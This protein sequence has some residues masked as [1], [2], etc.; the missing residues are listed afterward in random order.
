MP[1]LFYCSDNYTQK[2]G[3]NRLL[4]VKLSND[5]SECVIPVDGSI[6]QFHEVYQVNRCHVG[7]A[8][9]KNRIRINW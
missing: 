1:T 2:A 7:P 9:K 8:L 3:T 5:Y 6:H 4:V